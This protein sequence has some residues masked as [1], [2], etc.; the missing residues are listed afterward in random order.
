MTRTTLRI[1][2]SSAAAAVD[3]LAAHLPAITGHNDDPLARSRA[4]EAAMESAQ[5]LVALLA[6]QRVEALRAAA[7]TTGVA[8][9]ASELGITRQ[10]LYAL[11][12]TPSTDQT[13][14][15]RQLRRRAAGWRAEP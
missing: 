14:Q 10:R 12:R 1:T 4:L 9:L 6:A 11:I 8:A 15:A 7:A 3:E 2:T 13:E 5:H